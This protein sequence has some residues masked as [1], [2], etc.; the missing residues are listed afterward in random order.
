MKYLLWTCCLVGLS[1]LVVT[2]QSAPDFS[3]N[4]TMDLSR[5]EAAAQ[6]AVIGPISMAIQQSP[7]EIRIETTR[8]G[9]TEMVRYLPAAMKPV[10]AGE[11][12]GTFRWEGATL[13]TNM[14]TQINKQAVTYQ[15]ARSLNSDSTEMSVEVTLVVQHGYTT[16]GSSVVQS[17]NAP[18]TSKGKNVFLRAR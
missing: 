17:S 5:S 1:S 13:I 15:E 3:G 2:A 10:S 14:S 18:N 11:P 12:L 4:W 7:S 8:D 9:K 16:G 6:G